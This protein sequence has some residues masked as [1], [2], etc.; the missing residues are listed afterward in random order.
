[1][2]CKPRGPPSQPDWFHVH[3]WPYPCRWAVTHPAFNNTSSVAFLAA[4][5]TLYILC[6]CRYRKE[7]NHC[8]HDLHH[9]GHHCE[10]I[11]NNPHRVCICVVTC[12]GYGR[13]CHGG[14]VCNCQFTRT[15]STTSTAT[16]GNATATATGTWLSSL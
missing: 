8:E 10:V 9:A 16:S 7:C 3:R 1:M 12:G 5:I 14:E 11:V 2:P 4:L 13:G 15:H 6:G